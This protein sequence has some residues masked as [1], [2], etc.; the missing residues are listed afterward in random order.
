MNGAGKYVD[1]LIQQ[2]YA[3]QKTPDQWHARPR[4]SIQAL[5]EHGHR[6]V[7]KLSPTS[8]QQLGIRYGKPKN[9]TNLTAVKTSGF[10]DVNLYGAKSN[11]ALVDRILT[12]STKRRRLMDR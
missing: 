9:R 12:S 6:E 7:K 10:T 11:D 1:H 4:K 3:R 8:G 5:D 2:K